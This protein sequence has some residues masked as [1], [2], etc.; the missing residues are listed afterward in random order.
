M[1][2]LSSYRADDIRMRPSMRKKPISTEPVD[3]FASHD[4]SEYWAFAFPLGRCPHPSLGDGFSIFEP[5]FIEVLREIMEGLRDDPL[6][7][8]FIWVFFWLDDID[9]G[10]CV[11][12]RFG[13]RFRHRNKNY[14]I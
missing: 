14:K 12:E 2:E 7:F 10:T 3:I 1:L 8:F 4:V 6:R 9:P 5:S 13:E 11:F